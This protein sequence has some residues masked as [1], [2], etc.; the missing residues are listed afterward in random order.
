MTQIDYF[1]SLLS[2]F[3]Y[4]AGLGLEEIAVSHDI[5]IVYRPADIQH[6]LS[7]TGGMPVPKRHPARQAYRLQELARLSRIN[8]LELNLQPQHWP[9]DAVPASCAVIAVKNAD[10]PTGQLS[11]DFLKAC[12]AQD[13]DIS[14]PETIAAILAQHGFDALELT[15][16]MDEARAE[17]E[18]NTALAVEMGVFGAPFYIVGEEKFWGQDRL[19]HLDWHLG[20]RAS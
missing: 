14:D 4:L 20:Q 11:H 18:A 7:Q 5:E 19:S 12:W 6:V 17:F 16:A 13:R 3:T 15:G 9:V 10:G 8:G 2:P 1:Y